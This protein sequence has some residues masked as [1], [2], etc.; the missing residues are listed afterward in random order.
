MPMFEALLL[1]A[2]MRVMASAVALRSERVRADFRSPRLLATLLVAAVLLSAFSALVGER[3]HAGTGFIVRHGW[4][5][6]FYF[7]VTSE[8]GEQSQ[9]FELL[10]FVGNTLVYLG[11]ALLAWS[12]YRLLRGQRLK[13]EA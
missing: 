7:R 3:G 10:Y 12:L 1:F 6:P 13:G 8:T 4:P 9:A 5:K 11:A 2:L